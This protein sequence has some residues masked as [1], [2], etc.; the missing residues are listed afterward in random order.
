MK[1][2]KLPKG[3]PEDASEPGAACPVC[4]LLWP[5]SAV[6]KLL[7]VLAVLVCVLAVMAAVRWWPVS[8]VEKQLGRYD[9]LKTA[10]REDD[11]AKALGR[12]VEQGME[13]YEQKRFTESIAVFE[14][15]LERAPDKPIVLNYLGLMVGDLG[16]E[17]RAV[18]YF[19]KAIEVDPLTAQHYWN[20]ALIYYNRKDYEATEV[21]LREAMKYARL[22]SQYRLLYAFCAE[23]RALPND[24]IVARLR[25]VVDAAEAQAHSVKGEYLSAD[26]SLAKVWREAAKRLAAHGDEYGYGKL[27]KVAADSPKPEV[28]AFAQMLLAGRQ[29]D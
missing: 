2:E 16:E 12:V 3:V 23:E 5:C 24:V 20:L 8:S 6:G 9:K 14:K 13:L 27:R 21:Q 29:K 7:V 26:G 10:G 4:R 15:V 18:G 17:E 25:G 28:R 19:K 11:A 1:E 22:K